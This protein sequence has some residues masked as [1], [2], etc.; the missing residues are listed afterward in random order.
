MI[1]DI[2]D[3]IIVP[4][5]NGSAEFYRVADYIKEWLVGRG[6]PVE[7]HSFMMR[8]YFSEIAGAFVLILALSFLYLTFFRKSWLALVPTIFL[9]LLLLFEFSLGSPVVSGVVQMEGEN[10]VVSF[11]PE[12]AE[13]ELILSA[14]YDSKTQIFD[15]QQRELVYSLIMP[16]V[17]AG[18]LL[19]LLWWALHFRKRKPKKYYAAPMTAAIFILASYWVVLAF[20]FGGGFLA[21]PSPGAVDDGAAVAVLMILADEVKDLPLQNTALTI[22]FFAAEEV[23]MQGSQ[24]YLRDLPRNEGLPAYNVNLELLCQDGSYV[25]WAEDGVFTSRFATSTSLNDLLL[26]AVLEVTD[27]LL[28]PLEANF[29]TI[30]DSGSFLAAGIPS[31]TLGNAGCPELGTAFFHSHLDHRGRIIEERIPEAVKILKEFI[32][33]F[34]NVRPI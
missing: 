14:H 3:T 32:L 31:T 34:E 9:G 19:V 24:A 16:S 6:L 8:P 15:H 20:A 5:P 23:N 7:T 33:L 26:E 12:K 28:V 18:A 21:R 27:D 29:T 30:S 11:Q 22:I 1:S 25:Y 10:I 2:L 4:R 17:A 13:R